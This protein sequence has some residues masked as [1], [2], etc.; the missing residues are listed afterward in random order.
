MQARFEPRLPDADGM[1][2]NP[3]PAVCGI[4]CFMATGA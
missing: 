4:D 2:R 3:P 1:G